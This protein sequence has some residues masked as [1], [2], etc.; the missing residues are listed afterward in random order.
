MI[1]SFFS[2]KQNSRD[3]LT[4]LYSRDVVI[5]YANHLISKKVPF[6]LALIDID[7]FKYVN[8]NYGH[9][10]GDKII[11]AVANTLKNA[12]GE[13]VVI[14]RFGGDEFIIVFPNMIE[15]NQVYSQCSKIGA[16][17]ANLTIPD[18][19]ELN[20]TVTTGLSRFPEDEST[21]NK[22]LET[23]D[24]ALYRGKTK[25]RDCFIIYL[26]EKHANIELKTEND[27]TL[28][29]MH[30]HSL[31]FKTLLDSDIKGGITKLFDFFS[32]Y[33]MF[34]HV[35]IQK[36]NSI[37]FEKI[38]ELSRSKNFKPLDL[39]LIKQNISP[40]TE[41]F[42]LNRVEQLEKNEQLDLKKKLDEQGI[43]STLFVKIL[44][45]D[46]TYGFLRVDSSH[47]RIWQ[48]GDMDILLT[49]ARII[50]LILYD[51]NQEL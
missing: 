14:G 2:D 35:C 27:K 37:L 39:E 5:E 28:S 11:Q 40:D 16:S 47:Q 43:H 1:D 18:Q 13:D 42:Y 15:Y 4:N 10:I 36:G 50:G 26:S 24:K 25:G 48:H 46:K 49:A 38:H 45:K 17:V 21:Y 7:N 29:S 51:N 32:S 33:Y 3:V 19:T 22:L 23:A 41:L 12:V 6:A 9:I 8:D 34:D 20:V 44:C 30:I 31:V